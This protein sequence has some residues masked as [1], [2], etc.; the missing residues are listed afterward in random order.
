MNEQHQWVKR[1]LEGSAKLDGFTG[2]NILDWNPDWMS[3]PMTQA[4]NLT[5]HAALFNSNNTT[6]SNLE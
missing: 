3:E 2:T 4:P 6:S 5:R 1:L